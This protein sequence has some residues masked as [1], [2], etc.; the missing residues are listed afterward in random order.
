MIDMIK[1]L[2]T[3]VLGGFLFFVMNPLELDYTGKRNL[4][5]G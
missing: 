5:N 2:G 1:P 4:L 3:S